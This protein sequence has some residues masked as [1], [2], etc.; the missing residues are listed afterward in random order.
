MNPMRV[1]SIARGCACFHD[2][3]LKSSTF[4]SY[5]KSKRQFYMSLSLLPS[6]IA[7][8]LLPSS[9]SIYALVHT[10]LVFFLQLVNEKSGVSIL[11]WFLKRYNYQ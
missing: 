1:V 11:K 9:K 3:P 6:H 10:V 4:L 2:I 7:G 8:L 5:R